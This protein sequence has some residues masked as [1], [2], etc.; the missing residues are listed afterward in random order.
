MKIV[1]VGGFKKS[2]K[3]GHVGGQVFA[4]TSLL[5]SE[6]GEKMDWVLIDSMAETNMKRSF[7]KRLWQAVKRFRI[8]NKGIRQ[9]GVDAALIF[10]S[11]GF[12]FIEKGMMV[13]A[14]KRKGLPVVLA[15]RSGLVHVTIDPSAWKRWFAKR[16]VGKADRI[17]CQ[18]NYWK[19]YYQKL[20]G[21]PD[22][23]YPIINNWINS[24]PYYSVEKER[25]DHEGPNIKV[26]FLGWINKNKGVFD[27]LDAAK[28]LKD[29]PVEFVVGGNGTHFEEACTFVRTHDLHKVRMASWIKGEAKTQALMDSDVFILPSYL[30]GYPNA[31]LEAMMSRLCCIATNI[32]SIPDLITDGE[33]GWIVEPGQGD[34]I[35][36]VLKK[37]SDN[38]A[39]RLKT[40]RAG[41]EKVR[42]NNNLDRAVLKM[43]KLFE[44]LIS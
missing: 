29:E 5:E 18:S 27:L 43:E 16:V 31:L 6:W 10:C 7:R 40:A 13:L 36:E 38:P 8:F 28:I 37:L 21:G 20:G 12:S 4:C 3:S 42:E 2:G 25:K 33:T 17:I 9:P 11:A 15:P 41:F 19:S 44:E 23:K 24:V 1:F 35:A 22:S 26:L 34:Q 39:L 32:T 14:A 30:E